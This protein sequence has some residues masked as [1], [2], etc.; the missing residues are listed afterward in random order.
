MVVGK[1]SVRAASTSS[2]SPGRGPAAESETLP[3]LGALAGA[4]PLERQGNPTS[5][6]Q[7][8]KEALVA[9]LEQLRQ[10]ALVPQP[11]NGLPQHRPAAPTHPTP[12]PIRQAPAAEIVRK[13]FADTVAAAPAKHHYDTAAWLEDHL[14]VLISALEQR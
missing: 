12:A 11:P 4:G 7:N 14:E 1:D 13:W 5:P 9:P 6:P 8:T 2:G 10:N 3:G